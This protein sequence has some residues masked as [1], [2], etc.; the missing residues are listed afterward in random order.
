MNAHSISPSSL[1][2]VFSN[3]SSFP[4]ILINSL[5]K[6]TSLLVLLNVFWFAY[7]S[8]KAS[9]VVSGGTKRAQA[10]SCEKHKHVSQPARLGTHLSVTFWLANGWFY[11]ML[12]GYIFHRW[13]SYTGSWLDVSL[14]SHVKYKEE[15]ILSGRFITWNSPYISNKLPY[16]ILQSHILSWKKIISGQ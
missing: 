3:S 16:F 11:L 13:K 6:E 15:R 9:K 1:D 5:S 10:M 2:S 7:S 12:I 8:I 14:F 4:F